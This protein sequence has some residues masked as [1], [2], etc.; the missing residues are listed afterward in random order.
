M[1]NLRGKPDSDSQIVGAKKTT[2]KFYSVS[3]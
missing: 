3:G 1:M 2:Y